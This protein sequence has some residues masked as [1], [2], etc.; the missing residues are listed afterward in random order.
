MNTH[1]NAAPLPDKLTTAQA[2]QALGL[3]AQTLRQWACENRGT[4]KPIKAYG[5][6]FWDRADV[7]RV[8]T[9]AKK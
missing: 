8:R 7:E 3:S 2:A 1:P 9:E 4:I 5:R 6:L